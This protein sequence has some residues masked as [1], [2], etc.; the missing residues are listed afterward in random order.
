MRRRYQRV[1]PLY[2]LLDAWHERRA[3][4]RVR[5]R[6]VSLLMEGRGEAGRWLLAGCGTGRDLPFV[7]GGA[8]VL[9][10]DLSPRMLARAQRRWSRL[11]HGDRTVEF[12]AADLFSL[13]A[14][15]DVIM[16]SF[17]TMLHADGAALL[18]AIEHCLAPGGRVGVL[19][20]RRSS[21]WWVRWRQWLTAPVVHWLFGARFGSGSRG[22]AEAGGWEVEHEQAVL[23][24]RV[25]LLVLSQHVDGR[26]EDEIE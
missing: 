7:P 24:D 23:G 22:V 1:A 11:E 9:A 12:R 3:Y 17:V 14:E 15:A 5:E 18:E 16:L 25:W 6:L 21:H 13:E 26:A 4:R 8:S 19:E 10:V 2:D 20:W